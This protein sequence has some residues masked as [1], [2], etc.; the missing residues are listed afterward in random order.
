MWERLEKLKAA[1]SAVEAEETSWQEYLRGLVASGQKGPF[2]SPSG[3]EKYIYPVKGGSLVLSNKR[4]GPGK[5][6]AK[7]E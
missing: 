3:E 7:A 4:T 2:T 1:R 6:K 5:R